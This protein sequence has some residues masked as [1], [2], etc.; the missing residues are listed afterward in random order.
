MKTIKLFG[1]LQQFKAEWLLDVQTPAEA[2]R[3]IDAN[4]PGFLQAADQGDYV[5]MLVSEDDP[6][7]NRQV[8]LQNNT[9]AW[10][11]EVLMIVPRVG[12][13]VTAA[14]IAPYIG[15]A[16]E[17][18]YAVAAAAVINIALSMA[19]TAIANVI[20]GSKSNA[21][22][23]SLENYKSRPSFISNGPVNV[24]KSGNCYPIL[25]GRVHD[26]GSILLSV[27][28]SVVDS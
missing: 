2:L 15:V 27:D 4:R 17:S 18:F 7:L 5:A 21:A 23:G 8:T 12:G 28:Y 1:D 11:N 6:S 25:V 20:T 14:M 24:T 13:D 3:A 9:D 26:A 19:V 10:G 16:A 22:A